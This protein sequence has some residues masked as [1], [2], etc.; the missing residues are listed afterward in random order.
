MLGDTSVLQQLE[1]E[2]WRR[3]F[4]GALWIGFPLSNKDLH[5]VQFLVTWSWGHSAFLRYIH[6]CIC[7]CMSRKSNFWCIHH[8]F[9]AFAL[10]EEDVLPFPLLSFLC[11]W[12]VR[13]KNLTGGESSWKELWIWWEGPPGSSSLASWEPTANI[14]NC[15]NG[16]INLRMRELN[17]RNHADGGLLLSELSNYLMDSRLVQI[18]LR[19]INIGRYPQWNCVDSFY[20]VLCVF[21]HERLEMCSRS[22]GGNLLS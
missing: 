7:V 18:F 20:S 2:R 12:V 10:M 13:L 16:C 17:S 15:L 14:G 11:Y 6:L 8:Q 9:F 22:S 1:D 5:L 3:S 4:F 19:L 21:G